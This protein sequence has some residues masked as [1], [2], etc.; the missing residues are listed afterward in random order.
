MQSTGIL[1]AAAVTALVSLGIAQALVLSAK[2]HGHLTMDLP[3]AVQ[4][5]HHVPTP[6]V[7]GIA[8]YIGLAVAWVLAGT[9]ERRLLNTILVAGL[10]ALS[11]G[12]LEDVTKRVSVRSRLLVTM[13][14]GVL[15]AVLGGSALSQLDVPLLDDLLAFWPVAVLFTAFC[16]AGVSNAFNIIDGFHG[17]SSGT[18]ILTALG[19]ALVAASAGDTALAFAGVSLAAAVAGF[20][21][22]NFPWGKLFLGDGGAYFAG[23]SLAWLTVELVVRNPA[24]S[25]WCS[26]LLCGYPTIE[27]LYSIYRRRRSRLSPGAPDRAHLHSLVA[28]RIV[29]PRLGSWSPNFRN[30]AVS[31]LMWIA[32]VA[33]ILPA[34]LYPTQTRVLL[35][36]LAACAVA[37][38]LAYRWVAGA[39]APAASLMQELSLVNAA[40]VEAEETTALSGRS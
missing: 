16:V 20:W 17:L 8:I 27:V 19:M 40:E 25:P 12:L 7:G 32:A 5:F 26:V 6:R 30:A 36:V 14:S 31:V 4:K 34:V 28:T 23:F 3:G 2:R 15:A 29:Q 22:V 9:A 39:G 21:F 11:I 1:L 18:L 13:G 37:Y 35:P 10:P 33:T 24:V 38:H